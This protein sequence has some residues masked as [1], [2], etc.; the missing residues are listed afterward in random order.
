MRGLNSYTFKRIIKEI[1]KIKVFVSVPRI[2]TMTEAELTLYGEPVNFV[3]GEPV[4]ASMYNPETIRLPLS[5]VIDIFHSDYSISLV[6]REDLTKVMKALSDILDR[7]EDTSKEEDKEVFDYINEFYISILKQNKS[8][9]EKRLVEDKPK[10][11][12]LSG[13]ITTNYAN[14]V[15]NGSYID[16]TDI[17]VK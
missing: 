16:L 6:K 1:H 13:T 17:I 11:L 8:K 14:A 5:K 3:N 7:L 4:K 9:I 10:V 15:R 2:A 12:G